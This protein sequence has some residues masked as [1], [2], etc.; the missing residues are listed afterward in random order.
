MKVKESVAVIVFLVIGSIAFADVNLHQTTE[1]DSYGRTTHRV[2]K[3]IENNLDSNQEIPEINISRDGFSIFWNDSTPSVPVSNLDNYFSSYPKIQIDSENTKHVVY[4]NKDA[5][6]DHIGYKYKAEGG[7]WSDRIYVDQFIEVR[8]NHRPGLG[9]SNNGDLHVAFTYWA[10]ENAK[11]QISY[12]HYDKLNDTWNQEIIS[13]AGGSVS[14]SPNI[15]IF[16]SVENNPVIAWD[17]DYREDGSNPKIYLSFYNGTEWSDDQNVSSL[18]SVQS[19]GLRANEIDEDNVMLTYK[20]NDGTDYWVSCRIWTHSTQTLTDPVIINSTNPIWL[21]DTVSHNGTV[22]LGYGY[23]GI[24]YFMKYDNSNSTWEN[25]DISFNGYPITG[26]NNITPSM[27]SS[28]DILNI[29]YYQWHI[30]NSIWFYEIK[31][32]EVIEDIITQENILLTVEDA[33]P[34]SSLEIENDTN[35]NVHL[36]FAD[37]RYDQPG[38]WDTNEVMYRMGTREEVDIED[39]YELAITNYELKQNYPNP[40]NPHTRINYELAIT[41]YELAEIVVYNA[42]GQQVWSSGNLPFTR[43]TIGDSASSPKG[44]H[45]SP[46][47]FDG[48]KFN[49]GIYYYSLIV[50]GKKLSTKSMVLIK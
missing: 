33:H 49:S 9:L 50:D 19:W 31:Y 45:H 48:S 10:Y 39:N 28:G 29:A 42:M 22:Y 37:N 4:E 2:V 15:E 7:E 18:E 20:E 24:F 46:L 47:Y 13:N 40:F 23:D 30:V 8:N 16:C 32:S 21:F 35:G 38:G 11:N 17:E 5:S 43:R 41:N 25:L 3:E 36:V 26:N 6:G 34:N 1:F 44:I 14:M 12:S 27:C